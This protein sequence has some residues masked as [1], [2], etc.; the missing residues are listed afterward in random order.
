[1][2]AREPDGFLEQSEQQRLVWTALSRLSP[3]LRETAVLRYY[4]GL[5]YK[6]IADILDISPKTVES[7]MRLAHQK[8][9]EIIDAGEEAD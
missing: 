9:R 7:R 3:K 6:E 5:R 1:M 4:Y 8:L 2:K